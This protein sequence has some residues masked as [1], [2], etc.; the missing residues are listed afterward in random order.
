[1]RLS[2]C[3]VLL[4]LTLKQAL[5]TRG[6]NIFTKLTSLG[7]EISKM[8]EFPTDSDLDKIIELLLLFTK[9]MEEVVEWC[10]KQNETVLMKSEKFVEERPGFLTLKQKDFKKT[11]PWTD[12]ELNLFTYIYEDAE[13]MW[14]KLESFFDK[15]NQKKRGK[16]KKRN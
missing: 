13:N 3:I 9:D 7:E 15:K 6:G 4:L 10:Q 2:L 16:N 8:I 1:M 5:L 11:L 12:S 14:W